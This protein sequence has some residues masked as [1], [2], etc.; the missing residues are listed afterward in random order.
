MGI[1]ASDFVRDFESLV[2]FVH[3]DYAMQDCSLR[4]LIPEY[5][6]CVIKD[7]LTFEGWAG[8]PVD[9]PILE[10]DIGLALVRSMQK[11]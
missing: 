5:A 3:N 7:V 11:V 8:L 6:A 9:L 4:A 1:S 10:A 2:R